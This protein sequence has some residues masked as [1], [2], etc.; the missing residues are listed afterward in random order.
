MKRKLMHSWAFRLTAFVLAATIA[1]LA[2]PSPRAHAIVN[3]DLL[4]VFSSVFDNTIETWRDGGPILG[5]ETATF[6]VRDDSAAGTKLETFTLS[7]ST[8]NGQTWTS[9]PDARITEKHDFFLD[10][11]DTFGAF[12]VPLDPRFTSAIFKFSATYNPVIGA[13]SYPKVVSMGIPILQPGSPSDL[14]ITADTNTSI[15]LAWNDNS[16]MES[17]Y[18]IERAGG[19]GSNR[20]FYVKNTKEH[21]GQLNYVDRETEPDTY[22]VY[23]IKAIIDKY[24]IPDQ[25]KP[26]AL[27]RLGKSAK[28]SSS[29]FPLKD[30]IIMKDVPAN[31]LD[32]LKN[33]PALPATPTASATPAP[34]ATPTP[35]PVETP[36]P[37]Q[38]PIPT[39][40]EERL[41]GAS[42]WARAE[43]SEAYRLQLTTDAVLGNYSSAITR[44]EFAS[45]AVR[46]YERLSG[47][48]ATGSDTNPFQDTTNGDVLKASALGIVNGVSANRFSPEAGISRQQICVMLMRAI[49]AARPEA[50]LD[51]RADAPFADDGLIADWAKD[52]VYFAANAKIM[53]GVGSNRA[54]PLGST[55][56]EQA[57]ALV[58]R[59]YDRMK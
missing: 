36:P 42:G 14:V 6:A 37:G 20:V 54:D 8:D 24:S 59:A 27:V 1:G 38:S 11:T 34:V 53:G 4:K 12:T 57:I 40:A 16:N 47:N 7:Y 26:G 18:Q 58:K 25:L 22:Y 28:K 10:G 49:R 41:T 32:I 17:Y 33:N 21:V 30:I 2:I 15:S 50:S 3:I 44:E 29:L 31:L 35:T 13:R 56:R 45:I 52:A 39:I 43:I 5:G 46:L 51:T 9:L 55:T 48:P 23:T 19:T